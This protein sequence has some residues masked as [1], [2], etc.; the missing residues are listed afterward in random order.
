MRSAPLAAQFES[1]WDSYPVKRDKVN[2]E[3]AYAKQIRN[4]ATH[5][6][7]MRGLNVYVKSLA[8]PGAPS[9]KYAQ[10]WLNGKRWEDEHQPPATVTPIANPYA[11]YE[12]PPAPP[13][14]SLPWLKENGGTG[15]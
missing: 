15:D 2:A 14:E 1:F 9:P 4:G 3:K 12:T 6:Q 5:E 8:S 10:G 11:M 7:I 13:R